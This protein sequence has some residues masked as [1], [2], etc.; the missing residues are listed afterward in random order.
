[1]QARHHSAVTRVLRHCYGASARAADCA[2]HADAATATTLRRGAAST[3]DGRVWRTHA[4]EH[5][6]AILFADRARVD[7]PRVTQAETRE[8]R[9]ADVGG[10]RLGAAGGTRS[11]VHDDDRH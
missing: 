7:A 8:D 4:V 2:E 6:A 5:A 10:R 3:R 1:M 9:T 11:A